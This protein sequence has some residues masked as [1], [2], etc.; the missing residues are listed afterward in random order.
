MRVPEIDCWR[1]ST[2]LNNYKNTVTNNTLIVKRP[3]HIKARA[4]IIHITSMLSHQP[5]KSFPRQAIINYPFWLIA[6][7]AAANKQRVSE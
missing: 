6:A 3:N 7:C 5:E 2:N 1:I 4:F